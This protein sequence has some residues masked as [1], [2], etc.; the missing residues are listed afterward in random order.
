MPKFEITTPDGRFEV[1]AP[2]E[3]T[4]MQALKG[5]QSAEGP[6]YI[7]DMAKAGASG[8]ARGTMDL[9]G[10]PGTIGD[11]LNSGGQWALRKGYEAVTGSAPSSK[12]GM[13]ERFFAGPT[14]EVEAKLIGG[15]RNPLGG[16]NLRKQASDATGGATEYKAKTRPGKYAGTVGEFIPGAVAFGA[17]NPENIIRYGVVPGLASEAAGQMT[18]GS[19]LEPLA[20]AGAAIAAPGLYNAARRLVTPFPTSPE[21]IAA[22]DA[23]QNEGVDLTAGQRTGNKTLRYLESE[24]GG[25]A[26][27]QIADRQGEQFTSAALRRA[28]VTA[29]RATPD[30]I[31]DAFTRIGQ[32]FD[33]LAARNR[34]QPDRLMARDITATVRDYFSMVP[35]SQRAPVVT[36]LITDIAQNSANGIDGA[37]YQ[38]LRSRLDRLARGTADPQLGE[39][40]RG[41]RTA[42]DD[43]M[44]RTL[45]RTNPADFGAWRQARNEYRNM[46]VLEK[47]A[48]GAGEDAALGII[49]PSQLRGAT[50]TEQGRRA[51]A[52]GQ[53]DFADLARSGEAVM[54]PLPQSGTAPRTAVRA[55]GASLPAIAGAAAGSPLGLL[56]SMLGGIAGATVPYAIGRA[57][58]SGPGRAYL[59]NQLLGPSANSLPQG[60]ANALALLGRSAS[61]RANRDRRPRQ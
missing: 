18:E 16:A 33:D 56:G 41:I 47:A 24:L 38:A 49:S 61:D 11:V 13:V 54:K 1:T 21:R 7:E 30:V 37:T 57:A 20:R 5:Q 43:A 51:Y 23:L 32:Q 31:D 45:L 19:A 55:A 53:G 40:L 22:A 34:L 14:P 58:L 35:E 26:G 46:L 59:S 6:G 15:G 50:V 60:I 44:E 9:V 17:G 48:T 8:L 29:D 27:Q 36:D 3:Q 39:A 42:L 12:G 25:N 10:L 2:D 4:A 52:R 28:G